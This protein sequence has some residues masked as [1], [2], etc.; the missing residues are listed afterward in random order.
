MRRVGVAPV[1][2]AR[3][4]DEDGRFLRE[5]RPDLHRR[6][7]RP[8]DQPI[9]HEERVL[10]RSRGMPWRYPK[11]REVVVVRLDLWPLGDAVAEANEEV[12]DL[13]YYP[14]R[15]MQVALPERYARQSDVHRLFAQAF[16]ALAGRDLPR[17]RVEG[18]FDLPRGEV[19]RPADLLALLGREG[20]YAL[21]DLRKLRGAAEIPYPD[22]FEGSGRIARG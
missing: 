13:I 22:V 3:T 10:H 2:A 1:R 21:L 6:R 17:P 18:G 7:L 16:L 14:P 15:R 5:H 20:S 11:R 8:Q 19:R 12:D 4:H 9:I